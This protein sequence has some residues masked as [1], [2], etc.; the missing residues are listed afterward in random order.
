MV[1]LPNW[2]CGNF[3][4]TPAPVGEF[5]LNHEIRHFKETLLEMIPTNF[6]LLA[7]GGEGAK[8]SNLYDRGRFSS[9]VMGIWHRRSISIEPWSIK[10]TFTYFMIHHVISRGTTG[11]RDRWM[12]G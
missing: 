12:D 1:H 5:K 4:A 6:E 11:R 8:T 3:C 10:Y 7:R 2:D 9:F